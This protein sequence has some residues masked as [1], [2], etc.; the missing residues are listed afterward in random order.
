M[1]SPGDQSSPQPT[2]TGIRQLGLLRWALIIGF[3]FSAMHVPGALTA[4]DGTVDAFRL[5]E[6]GKSLQAQNDFA[7]AETS[8]RMAAELFDGSGSAPGLAA[9]LN[10][11]GILHT[12]QGK[13]AEAEDTLN[14]A[15]SLRSRIGREDAVLAVYWNNLGEVHRQMGRWPAAERAYRRSLRLHAR[16]SSEENRVHYAVA[17]NNLGAL[18]LDQ[19]KPGRAEPLLNKAFELL[20]REPEPDYENIVATLNNLASANEKLGRPRKARER[21]EQALGISTTKLGRR[22]RRTAITLHNLAGL[23]YDDGDFARAEQIYR[24]ALD[25]LTEIFGREHV[26]AGATVRNLAVTCFRL[27]RIAEAEQ[28]YREAL[29]IFKTSYGP[30]HPETLRVQANLAVVLRK[31]GQKAEAIPLERASRAFLEQHRRE[32]LAAGTVDIRDLSSKR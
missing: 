24:D 17:L 31:T 32:N 19:Q 6:A 25:M 21:L 4:S 16:H 7:G 2:G 26:L 5:L 23:F 1:N 28:L 20:S 13:F 29:G 22:T 27:G 18:Y 11:L 3:A 12:R 15:I 30:S 8:F 14:R 10:N 9:A